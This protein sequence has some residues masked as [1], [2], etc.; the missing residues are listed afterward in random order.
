MA[1]AA[2]VIA[3]P[4]LA[5]AAAPYPSDT[6]R[7]DVVPL[8]AG[9]RSFW[10]S[11]GVND[12]HGRVA[13]AS[14]LARDDRLVVWVN[15]HATRAQ[16][17]KALQDAEY[18]NATNTSYDQ[19][20]TVSTGMGSRIS[21]LYVRGRNAGKLPLTSRLINST[22]GTTGAYISTDK[23]KATFSHPR[24]YLPSDPST[25][26]VAGDEA[27]C[28]PSVTNGSSQRSIRT[29][30]PWADA[31]G[32]LRITRL[33]PVTDRTHQFSPRSVVLDPGYGTVGLCRGGSF[34]SGHTTTAYE[35]GLTLATLLPRFAPELLARA[36]ENA[37]NRLV[38]GVHYPLDLMG[39]RIDGEVALATRWADAK[40]RRQ[41]LVPART[42]LLRYLRASC[43]HSL[44]RCTAHQRR[45][46]SD[47]YGGARIP[48]G[49]SQVV[50]N[51][52]SAVRVYR[53]RMTYGFART[54]RRHLAPSVPQGA[55]AL[56]RTVFP[57]LTRAQR[58]SVLAQTQIASGFPLDQSGRRGSWQRLDLA[59]AM[60]ATVR[61]QRHGRVLV[62]ATG[63]PARVVRG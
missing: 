49:T 41:V 38:V 37:N 57:T 7:P 32:N 47:P 42:E 43:G 8:L 45:Y 36:S 62:V 9:Y 58:T 10:V 23:A 5:G 20:F 17:F 46:T 26:A 33:A 44:R 29:G 54:G 27:A 35:A 60:S 56:L 12:L 34:P 22:D 11:D 18:Q 31:R 59:A 21:R 40:F 51:R 13:D 6:H 3:T 14:T 30:R 52:T 2:V 1:A 39:G 63:G 24:P 16:K 19:S 55:S 61:V 53:E 28:A 25:P 50:T 4:T 48:G 15:Q